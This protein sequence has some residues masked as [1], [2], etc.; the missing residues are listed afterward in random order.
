MT[1]L[2]DLAT[3]DVDFLFDEMAESITYTPAGGEGSTI[4]AIV[5]ARSKTLADG[6]AGRGTLEEITVRVK[7]S[8]VTTPGRGDKVTY[9]TKEYIVERDQQ[10][11]R[12]P[13]SWLIRMVR[14]TAEKMHDEE[15]VRKR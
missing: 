1:T 14:L 6:Q 7:E 5:T 15:L 13:G 11:D 10:I 12:G 8:D 9:D 3:N 2:R 4:T